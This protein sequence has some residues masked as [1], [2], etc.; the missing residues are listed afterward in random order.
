M[1]SKK[2]EKRIMGR[3]RIEGRVEKVEEYGG[4][5]INATYLVR[6]EGGKYILQR[7]NSRLFKD[8]PAL[9]RNIEMVTEESRR[10]TV[11]RGGDPIREGLTLV[12]T[13]EDKPYYYCGKEYYRVYVFI[14]KA[15]TYDVVEK[16]EHFFEAAVAF[17]NF[18]NMLSSFDAK[19]LSETIP[20]FHN[21]GVR[22]E[23][24]IEAVER[25]A[26]GRAEGVK[27][28]IQWVKDRQ[29]YATAITSLLESGEIP[30]RVT[31]ND[32]KL[33]NVMIDDE[34][35]K[36]IAVV[37]LDT[38]M[39]GSLCYDFGDAIRFGC[40]P[41]AEDE[42][43]LG[44]VVFQTTLFEQFVKGYLSAVGGSITG[45]EKEKLALSAIVM[46]YE[47]GMRF[48]TDY[49]NG[50]TYFRTHREGQNLDRART[51]FKLVS[52]MEGQLDHMTNI[53]SKY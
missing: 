26:Y 42:R 19:Q 52:D 44:K 47:C 8:V 38:I 41:A 49:L 39:P 22:Y 33:N 18:A 51:Q 9:M 10:R 1:E 7:I 25:D 36:G 45:T 28:E 6:S 13:K 29:E 31:H 17:G 30:Y 40:N 24:F 43:D 12:K 46:T 11:E 48:L 2:I 14:D 37:D 5:H 4:G 3:F 23:S 35:G 34:T 32:T 15:T 50:D 16:P 53:V 21:T 27:K 20:D